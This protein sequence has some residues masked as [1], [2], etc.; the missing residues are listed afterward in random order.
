MDGSH[1]MAERNVTGCIFL[2]WWYF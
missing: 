2:L 1:V